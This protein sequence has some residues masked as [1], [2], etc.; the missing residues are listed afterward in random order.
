FKS[1]NTTLFERFF[2]RHGFEALRNRTNLICAAI[3]ARDVEAAVGHMSRSIDET[4]S[5]STTLYG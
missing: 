3:R 2:R 4:L 5:G 1:P